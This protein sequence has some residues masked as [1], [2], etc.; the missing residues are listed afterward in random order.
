MAGEMQVSSV[1]RHV[2]VAILGAGMS[3]I[4]MGIRLRQQGIDDFVILEKADSVGGTWRDN[5]YPGIA[6]D[7]PSH[8]YSFS[9]ELNPDWTHA[10]SGGA[11][12]WDY[13]RRCVGKYGLGPH[14]RFGAEVRSVSRDDGRWRVETGSG[15]VTADLVVS[16]LGGLHVPKHADIAGLDA[17][18][19]TTFHTAEWNHDVD[20]T[21][22]RVAIIGTGASAA[23]VLP[24]IAAQVGDVTVFQRTAAWVFPR[25][26]REIPEERRARFRRHPSLMRLYRWFLWTLMDVV[27]VLSLRRGGLLAKRLKKAGLDHLDASVRDPELRRKLTPDYEPG[28]KR[29]VISDDYLSSFDRDNVHL[30]T[31]RV[32]AIEADG[33]RDASGRLHPIDVLIQATGFKPFDIAEYVDIRGRDGQSL[34][35]VWAEHVES[36]RTMMVPGFPNFFMLLG[37]NSATGHTSALIMIESQA[38]YVIECLRLMARHGIRELDPDPEVVARYNSRLQ[39]DMQKMVFSGGCNAWYTDAADRNFTLWPYSA[40]RFIAEN[41]KPKRNEFITR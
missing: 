17:F 19:G 1:S 18:A 33:V 5:T 16:G 20:L 34:R 15:T 10:Y 12:I 24:A 36:H 22:K 30:V 3:G 28:C 41:W 29:R 27:G 8:V 7:V 23:Q 26:A 32:V 31:E 21:G 40:F 13:C 39:R 14:I 35:S 6:C 2:R 11:E 37:P 38:N 25:M 9:F 4:C